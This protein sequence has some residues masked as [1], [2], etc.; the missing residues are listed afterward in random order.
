[1]LLAA[2]DSPPLAGSYT[3]VRSFDVS[4][5]HVALGFSPVRT[6]VE[7]PKA[8]H[9]LTMHPVPASS[10]QTQIRKLL[11]SYS[12]NV[13]PLAG[14]LTV[15]GYAVNVTAGDQHFV[16][17]IDTGRSVSDENIKPTIN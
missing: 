8:D 9:S 13:A 3:N 1:M 2:D 15:E 17:L 12:G 11:Y 16:L 7:I 5:R 6:N 10:Y 14:D 4:F